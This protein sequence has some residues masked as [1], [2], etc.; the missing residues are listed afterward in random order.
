MRRSHAF[1]LLEL[2]VTLALLALLTSLAAPPMARL[3]ADQQLSS[4]ANSWLGL[5]LYARQEAMRQ[6]R[7][8]QLC[9]WRDNRCI[10]DNHTPWSVLPITADS[11]QDIL[12]S[13]QL[14]GRAIRQHSNRRRYVFHPRGHATNGNLT[15]CDSQSRVQARRVVLNMA[16]RPRVQRLPAPGACP[17]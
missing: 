17:Q 1:T 5:A 10:S 6:G 4:Q 14:S 2:L 13:L 11:D 15:L 9:Q 16:G 3:V 8:V 7:P 12:R